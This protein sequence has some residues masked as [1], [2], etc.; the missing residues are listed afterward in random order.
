MSHA[1]FALS[2]NFISHSNFHWIV[3][4]NVRISGQDVGRGT[5]SQRHAMFV[6]Q[7]TDDVYI[8]FNHMYPQQKAFFEVNFYCCFV[9]FDIEILQTVS[10]QLVASE[11]CSCELHRS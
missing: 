8:P 4:F 7:E 1:S 6:D 5:F 9:R 3:G 11:C 2:Q 10:S